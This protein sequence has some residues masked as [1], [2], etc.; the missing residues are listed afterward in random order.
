MKKKNS[1]GE[2]E[3]P[4]GISGRCFRLRQRFAQSTERPSRGV[5]SGNDLRLF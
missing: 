3:S 4:D 5:V 1:C 2:L